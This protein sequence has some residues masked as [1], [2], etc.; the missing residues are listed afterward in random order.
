[1]GG[2]IELIDLRHDGREPVGDLRVK[3]SALRGVT[4][5]PMR[6]P[7]MIDEYPVLAVLASLAEGETRMEGLSELR[8]KETDPSVL[9]A[10]LGEKLVI[11]DQLVH[12][13]LIVELPQGTPPMV[14]AGEPASTDARI[15]LES[16]NPQAPEVLLR[17]QFTVEP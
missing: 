5:P 3:A 10:T 8:V 13:P 12:V 6:A 2:E 9:K 14:R 4:V 15:V 1:M 17:V 7:S 16:D 11:N